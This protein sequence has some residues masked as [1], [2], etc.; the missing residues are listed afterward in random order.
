MTA[1]LLSR[2]SFVG[3]AGVGAAAVLLFGRSAT[4]AGATMHFAVTR[5]PAQWRQKLGAQRY[6]VLREA[7]TERPYSSPLNNEHRK[8][9]FAC[10]GCDLPLFSSETKFESGTGWPSFYQPLDNAVG[11][12]EDRTFGMLRT[13]IHC[14]RCGGHLGHVFDDGPK[15]TGLR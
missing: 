13:E 15:P 2:R 1:E 5:T 7:A 9:I 6:A 3:F 10:A 11:K 14:R 12:T 4:G 8:G